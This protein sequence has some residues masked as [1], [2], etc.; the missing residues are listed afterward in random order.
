MDGLANARWLAPRPTPALAALLVVLLVEAIALFVVLPRISDTVMP[1]YGISFADDYDRLAYNLANGNGYRFAPGLAETLMREPGYPLFLAGVFKIF[2]YSLAAARFANFVLAIG[3]ALLIVPLARRIDPRPAVAAVAAMVFLLHPG[4]ILAEARGGVELLFMFVVMLFMVALYRAVENGR[5]ADYVVAGA[6][7]GL[8]VL[9]RSTPILFPALLL[10]YLIAVSHGAKERRRAVISA[11]LL[12]VAMVAVMSPWIVRNFRLTGELVP[13]SSMLG[14]SVQSGQYICEH[15]DLA[16]GFQEIDK[17]GAVPARSARARSLGYAFKDDYYQ[18]FYRTGDEMAFNKTLL[19]DSMQRYKDRPGIV[20]KCL[21]ANLF[22]F[23]FAGK[24]WTVTMVNML[25]QLPLLAL[26][27]IGAWM[28]IR[29]GRGRHLALA[30]LFI[31]YLYLVHLPVLAQARYSIPLVPFLA[32]AASVA[33]IRGY[34]R[35][36]HRSR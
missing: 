34:A 10:V 1:H 12:V 13:T 3:I 2:G 24:S 21:S 17:D 20:A 30:G 23:W 6:L 5:S 19:H 29:S 11:M 33:L 18:Y 31:G 22:N 8:T 27:A 14:V 15:L 32:I 4:V 36:V 26:A 25:V 16:H 28:L 9:I 35:V 7:L